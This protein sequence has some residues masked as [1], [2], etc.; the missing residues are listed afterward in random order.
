M[1]RPTEADESTF[2]TRPPRSAA[3]AESTGAA[4]R[5][6]TG[7]V[8]STAKSTA[9][10]TRTRTDAEVLD[11][12]RLL[13]VGWSDDL[14]TAERLRSELRIGQSRARALRD[15]LQA[16]RTSQAAEPVAHDG[17]EA[18]PLDGLDETASQR[19]TELDT[20]PVGTA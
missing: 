8:R 10:R 19:Q 3:A 11:E 9:D 17:M 18:E 2:A 1:P 20:T 5:R 7:R 12:A 15:Q 16:E 13:T 14:L 4:R 6:A